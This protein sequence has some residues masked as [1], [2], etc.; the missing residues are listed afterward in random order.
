MLDADEA[1]VFN[2]LGP[3][4]DQHQFSPNDISRSSRVRLMRITKLITNGKMFDL[5]PNS[6]NHSLKKCMK[7]S[8]E[9]LYLDLEAERV[10]PFSPKCGQSQ[11]IPNF[12]L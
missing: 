9:N 8:L 4:S 5:K 7:I 10:N 2:P 6:L 1:P 3:M 12:T 11:K